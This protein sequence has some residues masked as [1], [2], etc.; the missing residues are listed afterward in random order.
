MEERP[1]IQAFFPKRNVRIITPAGPLDLIGSITTEDQ[2]ELESIATLLSC[3]V[4]L[5][6]KCGY[7][8][9]YVPRER[10][11]EFENKAQKLLF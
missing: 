11:K 2:S 7:F 5:Q 1:R 9:V 10:T 8:D 4:T 3:A 6:K